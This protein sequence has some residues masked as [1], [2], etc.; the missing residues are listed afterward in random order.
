MLG[1]QSVSVSILSICTRFVGWIELDVSIDGHFWEEVCSFLNV[2]HGCWVDGYS[3][4][5]GDGL[6]CSFVVVNL[7]TS[8]IL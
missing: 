8:L 2:L 7:H 5:S 3:E 4:I 1:A 6:K